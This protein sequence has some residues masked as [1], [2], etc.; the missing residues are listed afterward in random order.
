MLDQPHK[1]ERMPIALVGLPGS[2]KS[3]VGRQ[4]A[5]R[6]NLSFLDSDQIIEER[7]GCSI[8]EFFEREGEERFRSIE[9]SIIDELTQKPDCVIST[10]GGAVLREQ[11][12]AF[13]QT[14]C[15]CIY[16]RSTPEDL[17]RRLRHDRKRPLLQVS[18]PL[19]ALK[20]LYLARDSLYIDASQWSVDTGRPTVSSLVTSILDRLDGENTS[21]SFHQQSSNT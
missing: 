1:K 13:L 8:R 6:A 16:L 9:S 11:N 19:E 14:R 17:I 7:I 5:R 10:G 3:T 15:F 20:N 4:L 2:G 21:K 18:N 12:R